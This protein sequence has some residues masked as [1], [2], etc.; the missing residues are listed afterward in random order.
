VI[1]A[2][3]GHVD[4]G[5][6]SVVKHLSGVDTDSLEEERRRGLTIN[7]GY[8]YLH[9]DTDTRV[10]LIDV[11]GHSRFINTMI[12]GV[13]GIDLALIVVAAD[14]GPMPQT[15]E[16]LEVLRLLGIGQYAIVIT[17]IDRV[18]SPRVVEVTEVLQS[19]MGMQWPVF[20]VNN[21]DGAGVDDLKRYLLK[22]AEE[23]GAKSRE[24]YFRLSIDRGFLLN[25]IGL[26]AT[27]TAISGSVS[28]GDK[29]FLLPGNREVRVRAIHSQNQKSATGQAGQRCALQLAGIERSQINRGD[30]LHASAQTQVSNRLDVRLEMSDRLSFK[31]KHLCPVKLY[32]GAKLQP[33][34][35]YFLER[36]TDGNQLEA[37]SRELA[38]LIVDSPIS[39]CRGDRFI[40]RDSSESIT[41]GGGIVL[42]PYAD[43]NPKLS[44]KGKNYLL[45]MELPT[46]QETLQK[47]LIDQQQTVNLSQF[48]QACNLQDADLVAN[49]YWESAEKAIVG[50]V[51]GWH[52]ENPS[53]EGIQSGALLAELL[54]VTDKGLYWRVLDNLVEQ[55]VL[56]WANGCISLKG[57][58]SQRSAEEKQYW[59]LIE[60]ALSQ[61][62][63][64][65][66]TLA[67]L[68]NDLQLD[69][70]TV[71]GVLQRAVVEGRVFRL[72]A[73]RFVL[74]QQLSRFAQGVNQ[75]AIAK[76]RFSVVDIKNHLQ[77]GRNSS[78]ELLEYFD[79]IGFTRR[80]G[81]S[82]AV[83]DKTLPDRI[84][85]MK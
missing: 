63:H 39:C 11:P 47:L 58:R 51:Q 56:S 24:G 16:H 26:V 81:Q 27:G 62:S 5:K 31:V 70:K 50:A 73:K 36:Q 34:K 68:Q 41:L 14:E 55:N 18:K 71:E 32:I 10:G 21:I 4:H 8:A 35:L 23:Q 40:L 80:H 60:Q 76:P 19:I 54:P 42:D 52:K 57:F 22:M 17:H 84:F 66:P 83:L 67:D 9:A 1:V 12:A 82:R 75:L 6:T 74:F 53:A 72:G 20:E 78:V 48:K 25:G 45:A 37:G 15:M 28:E 43:Y 3:A 64:Q 77:L 2:T 69:G 38:Q 30:W 13:S 85:T 61:Y 79:L 59:Q 44:E 33:A 7:L 46:P 29:L 49:Q 65:I